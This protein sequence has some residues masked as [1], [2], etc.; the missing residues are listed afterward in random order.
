VRR[1]EHHVPVSLTPAK[2][3]PTAA[4]LETTK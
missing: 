3:A 4:R 2:A 1:Q